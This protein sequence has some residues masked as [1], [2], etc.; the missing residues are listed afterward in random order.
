MK[1]TFDRK[2]WAIIAL[3]LFVAAAL[4]LAGCSNPTGSDG[5]ADSDSANGGNGDTVADGD[6]NATGGSDDGTGTGDDDGSGSDS[7][8]NTVSELL[9]SYSITYSSG[10]TESGGAIYL[11]SLPTLVQI[12]LTPTGVSQENPEHNV[13]F[14]V[15][16]GTG[17]T[18]FPTGEYEVYDP[19]SATTTS[20]KRVYW[21][22]NPD[23][24]FDS[25]VDDSASR[26]RYASVGGTITIE[27]ADF[28]GYEGTFNDV[29][30]DEDGDPSTADDQVTIS[31][32]FSA[33]SPGF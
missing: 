24:G 18:E 31:G 11:Q 10:G 21:Y 23:N 33:R 7:D 13:D 15:F 3:A 17:V 19:V 20:E 9:G 14:S 16:P 27:N 8:D 25:P 32:S 4:V 1:K 2:T 26:E 5:D 12:S 6:D 28:G 22:S 29:V 30:L